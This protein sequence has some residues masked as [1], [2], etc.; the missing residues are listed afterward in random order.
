MKRIPKVGDVGKLS[1]HVTQTH[2]IDFADEKMPA[3]LSTPWLIW[4]LEQA[5]RAAL[6]EL[7]EDHETTVGVQIDVEHLAPTP[8]GEEVT[9]V[10]RVINTDGPVVTFQIEANDEHEKIARGLH[11]RRVIDIARFSRRVAAKT[12]L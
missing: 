1:F 4:F 8:L 5:G 10:A 11:R 9:C 3:V 7:L 2:A 6:S 12:T